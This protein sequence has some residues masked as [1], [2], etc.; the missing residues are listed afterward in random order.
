MPQHINEVTR[1]RSNN[2][3]SLLD[4]MSTKTA[5]KNFNITYLNS[6]GKSDQEIT[7]AV[8]YELYK[9]IYEKEI[10]WNNISQRTD[11]Y[12]HLCSVYENGINRLFQ[13][14]I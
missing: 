11:T 8:K 12:M 10:K 2:T 3:P 4:L 9:N 13:I 7:Y 5:E 14:G 6:L 1:M